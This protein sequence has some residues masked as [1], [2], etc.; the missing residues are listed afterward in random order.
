MGRL[1]SWNA[2]NIFPLS[3]FPISD[4]KYRGSGRESAQTLIVRAVLCALGI[5][6]VQ[7]KS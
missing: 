1:K 6:A 2:E 7:F 3:V 5:L 4:F